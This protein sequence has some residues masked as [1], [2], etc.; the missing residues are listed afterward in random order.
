VANKE[1]PMFTYYVI[2]PASGASEGPGEVAAASDAAFMARYLGDWRFALRTIGGATALLH[3]EPDFW[4]YAQQ[5]S[6]DPHAIP[7][8]VASANP[9][10]CAGHE[11]SIAGLGRCMIAMVRKYAPN[12]RV[13]LHA[14][15]WAT[16]IDVLY[17]RDPSFDVAAEAGKVGAFLRE[18]GAGAS[19]YLVVEMSDR[20]AGYYQSVG[21]NTWWDATNATL[22]S[23][24]QA[25][26]WAK[27]LAESVGKPLLWWQIPVGNMSQND[28]SGHWKDNRVQ[29]FFDH[30]RELAQ[31]H[32]IGIAFGAGAT[33]QTT[34]S[35]DGGSLVGW[36]KSYFSAGGAP[37]CQ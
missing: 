6:A 10:D 12:A 15:G 13:G 23:F 29:Y 4:G 25:F 33:G 22:P 3:I 14:S 35:T 7:A 18:C 5:L 24:R 36:A 16:R 32:G 31:A 26:T 30:P 11:N 2:L 17:N 37:L 8:A 19:D 20:D 27:A 34:P 28:T 1:I 9:T 21:R